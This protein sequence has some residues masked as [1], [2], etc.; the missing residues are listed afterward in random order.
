MVVYSINDLEK[1]SGVKAHTLRIWEKR[2]HILEPRRTPSNIRYYLDEDL[3]LILNIALL[4]RNGIKISKI[5]KMTLGEIHH[6]VAEVADIDESFEGQLDSLTI[7]L[8]DLDEAKFVKLIN[9]NIEERGFIETM[10][11]MIYPLLDKL[12]MMWMSGSIKT[13]HEKFVSNIIK[14]KCVVEIDGKQ[15]NKEKLFLIYLP[16]G[17]MNELS[18][19]FLHYLIVEQG[20]KVINAGLDVSIEDLLEAKEIRMP[21]YLFTIINDCMTPDQFVQYINVL[22][23]EF[24]DSTVLLSGAR[25]S[26]LPDNAPKN[27]IVLNSSID[28]LAYLRGL[29]EK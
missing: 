14:R 22:S 2:Y 6:K 5:A 24:S 9:K 8:I 7:S 18:L 26:A 17:E 11:E 4:N 1:L 15:T 27:V 23:K 13:I 20:Y 3:K 21:D 12:A 25:T 10:T 28:T 19:L 29:G 16:E